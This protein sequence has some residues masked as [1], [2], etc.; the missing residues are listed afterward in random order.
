[1]FGFEMTL[2]RFTP[3][4]IVKAL[5]FILSILLLPYQPY[6]PTLIPHGFIWSLVFVVWVEK[7]LV[8]NIAKARAVDRRIFEIRSLRYARKHSYRLSKIDRGNC[9]MVLFPMIPPHV[10]K[11]CGSRLFVGK[12]PD[13]NRLRPTFYTMLRLYGVHSFFGQVSQVTSVIN[14]HLTLTGETKFLP[15][16]TTHIG[17][18]PQDVIDTAAGTNA[19]RFGEPKAGELFSK[20]FAKAIVVPMALSRSQRRR[21]E[22]EVPHPLLFTDEKGIISDHAELQAFRAII[23]TIFDR[24]THLDQT[25]R[26]TLC[27]G[28]GAAETVYLHN[29]SIDHYYHMS[30]GKDYERAT[31]WMLES[32]S[33]AVNAQSKRHSKLRKLQGE[34]KTRIRLQGMQEVLTEFKRTGQYPQGFY[35]DLP[36]RKYET[37]VLQDSFYNLASEDWYELFKATDAK[38]AYGYGMLPLE[39]VFPDMPPNGLYRTLYDPVTDM[40]T[41]LYGDGAYSN[42]YTHRRATWGLMLDRPVLNFPTFSIVFEIVARAGPMAM[43]KAIRVDGP[44]LQPVVRSVTLPRHLKFVRMLEPFESCRRDGTVKPVYF[45]ARASEFWEVVNYALSLDEKSLSFPNLLAFIRRRGGGISLVNK[46]LLEPW[47]LKISQYAAFAMTVFLYVRRQQSE[48]NRVAG[49]TDFHRKS[50]YLQRATLFLSHINWNWFYQTFVIGD[51]YQDQLVIFPEDTVDQRE[52]VKVLAKPGR[53]THRLHVGNQCDAVHACEVCST[54]VPKRG[55]QVI[56]CEPGNP[57]TIVRMSTESL[58]ELRMRFNDTDGDAAGLKKVKEEAAKALPPTAFEHRVRMHYLLGGPGCGKSYLIR[59]I[60][61]R[62][63]GVAL[64][65]TKLV[66]D[67]MSIDGPDGTYNLAA[68]TLHRAVR[69]IRGVERLYVDEFTAVDWETLQCIIYLSGATDVFIVGDTRQTKVQPSE[70]QYIGDHLDIESLPRHTLMRNFRNPKDAVALLNRNFGYEM[71]AMSDIDRSIFIY[72]N[73]DKLPNDLG[74]QIAFSHATCTELNLTSEKDGKDRTVRTYQGSTVGPHPLTLWIDKADEGLL[75]SRE[76]TVVAL[77]RHKTRLNIIHND[78]GSSREWLD[79]LGLPHQLHDDTEVGLQVTTPVHEQHAPEVFEDDEE[80]GR[81]F[82]S[83]EPIGFKESRSIAVTTSMVLA[84]FS[85]ALKHLEG[86]SFVNREFVWWFALF[87]TMYLNR[88]FLLHRDSWVAYARSAPVGFIKAA[89]ILQ[90]S[91]IVLLPLRFFFPVLGLF[92]QRRRVGY[93]RMPLQF[94]PVQWSLARFGLDFRK[95]YNLYSRAQVVPFEKLVRY[96]PDWLLDLYQIAVEYGAPNTPANSVQVFCDLLEP[97]ATQFLIAYWF[98][99]RVH[100]QE[101]ILFSI[102]IPALSKD[103][104]THDLIN[105]SQRPT[106]GSSYD[107]WYMTYIPSVLRHWCKINVLKDF[108]IKLPALVSARDAY[109][110]SKDLLGSWGNVAFGLEYPNMLACTHMPEEPR[111]GSLSP[112]DFLNPV[113]ARG[114]PKASAPLKWTFGVL[115]GH[116]FTGNQPLQVLHTVLARYFNKK[117][118]VAMKNLVLHKQVLD[119]IMHLASTELLERQPSGWDEDTLDELATEFLASAEAKSYASQFQGEDSPSG[120]QIRFHLKS[121]FKPALSLQKPMNVSKAGQGISAWGKDA[122]IMFGLCAKWINFVALQ[123]FRS[124]VIYDNRMSPEQ[125]RTKLRQHW[126]TVDRTAKN[127]VTDFEMYDSQQDEFSQ[128]LE[129]RF[130]L[131]LG[132]SQE[133]IDHYYSFRVGGKLFAPGISGRLT[134]EKSS[135]EPLTLFGNS[136]ISVL[137]ANYLL[138]GEGPYVIAVKGDDGFKRQQNMRISQENMARLAQ[139]CRLKIKAYVEDTAEFCGFAIGQRSFVPSIPRKAAKI[140]G[141]EFRDYEHFC[142]YRKSLLDWLND[143]NRQDYSDVIATNCDLFGMNP[144]ETESMLDTLRSISHLDEDCFYSLAQLCG[145]PE[146]IQAGP[147]RATFHRI[148]GEYE[149]AQKL[150]ADKLRKMPRVAR[151]KEHILRFG[152]GLE[153]RSRKPVSDNSRHD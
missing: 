6:L 55:K 12:P 137:L 114:H 43:F 87:K 153:T 2:T 62:F 23:R 45:S 26:P 38:V 73:T 88:V 103:Q 94:L 17:I 79:S 51:Q 70:G 78:S 80:V 7:N 84:L 56:K 35:A 115:A 143:I 127:G 19:S 112:E 11:Y 122:Q 130:L 67:Y 58:N 110:F 95:Y 52:Y 64:P 117:P 49:F 83:E 102:P 150:L 100:P 133:F 77:S 118:R 22:N 27:V 37:L 96:C 14:G 76:L 113:N 15:D 138:R 146:I 98:S 63:D 9:W 40:S 140:L 134:T 74:E 33:K 152:N 61:K 25:N 82:S 32:I 142:E 124:Q 119:E 151:Y 90:F 106:G 144:S 1:M 149:A 31:A 4:G 85:L 8:S 89:L 99:Y 28:S 50:T 125:L 65:F 41:L 13:I 36:K 68:K 128:D 59:A 104:A 57:N 105:G 47:H 120:R 72:K 39:L 60:A 48:V 126:E 116:K 44:S 109:L 148:P 107:S 129:K 29:S 10:A 93:P 34:E 75:T 53:P 147:S 16:N 71:Q 18:N 121:I 5:P 97:V 123:T 108:E 46:E 101:D 24:I 86:N 136:V 141:H 3:L 42:G 20:A 81:I 139:V 135:G 21:V 54:F 91:K 111:G 145:D 131:L 66:A 69:D 30:E 92:V 132:V